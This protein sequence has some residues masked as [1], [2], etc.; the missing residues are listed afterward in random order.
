MVIEDEVRDRSVVREYG[1]LIEHVSPKGGIRVKE[2]GHEFSCP[3]VE[4]NIKVR[5]AYATK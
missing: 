4:F 5:K 2:G 1:N 3:D